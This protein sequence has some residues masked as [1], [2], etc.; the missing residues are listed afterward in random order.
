MSAIQKVLYGI[1]TQWL[2]FFV[3]VF[4][5]QV[6]LAD[7]EPDKSGFETKARILYDELFASTPD[8][9]PSR[10]VFT[11]A[12]KGFNN[13]KKND[14]QLK[15]NILTIIDFSRSSNEKRMWVVDLEHKE[16]VFN[17]LVAH[18]VNS[19][20][21]YAKKFS[22]VPNTNMSSLGFF[23][24]GE[25][26]HGKHGLSLFLN[27]K[28]RGF[29]HNARKRAIVM[30]GADYVSYDFI[31]KYGRLGRSFGCPSV[32]MHIYKDVIHTISDGSCLFIYYPDKNFLNKSVV[33][34]DE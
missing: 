16:V 30:H 15:K 26:Y 19:G 18:G 1:S 22:N 12:L 7:N 27:G 17:D 8:Q 32:S 13:L 10:E 11:I 20:N 14:N 24:T 2:L 4:S 34:N 25:T 29:N 23:V 3:C 21:E 6:V 5:V 31:K 33:L 28:D 9:I